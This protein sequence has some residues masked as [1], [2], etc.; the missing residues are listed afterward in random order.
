VLVVL[1]LALALVL[2]QQILRF[3][4]SS[5]R[6]MLSHSQASCTSSMSQY[7]PE[8]LALA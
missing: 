5:F 6:P 4:R 7:H 2:E 8:T 3:Q 1:A